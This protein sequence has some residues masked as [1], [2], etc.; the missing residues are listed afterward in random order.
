MTKAEVRYVLFVVAAYV[1]PDSPIS[2]GK[3]VELLGQV[4]P[5]LKQSDV[6]PVL[7]NVRQDREPPQDA[8][9]LEYDCRKAGLDL[10]AKLK[11]DLSGEA[12]LAE[13][14]ASS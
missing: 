7:F 8:M 9:A 10:I 11:E 2:Y 12:L 6:Y 14:E 4:C 3:L 13:I 1:S 5:G